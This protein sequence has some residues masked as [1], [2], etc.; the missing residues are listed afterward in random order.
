M[1]RDEAAAALADVGRTEQKL[2]EHARWPFQRHAMFGLSEGLLIAG[3]A[4]PLPLSGAMTA[5]ALALL[6]VCVADDRR[7]HGMFVSGWQAGPTRWVT[8][9]LLVFIVVMA[10]AS[11]AVRD[12]DTAQPLGYLFGVVTFAVAT[13]V[14]LRWEKI[15]RRQLAGGGVR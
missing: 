6:A 11:A 8:M 15:Y 5:A 9:M 3:V 13:G 12:G 4:Q 14:S 7:R 10:A 2:A 1:T